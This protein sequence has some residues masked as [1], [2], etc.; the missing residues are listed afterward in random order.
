MTLLA[1][2]GHSWKETVFEGLFQMKERNAI[3]SLRFPQKVKYIISA[4][5][6]TTR[7][8]ATNKGHFYMIFQNI[9]LLRQC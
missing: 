8:N 5:L 4:P 2:E 1:P 6:A 7:E 9:Y 3:S